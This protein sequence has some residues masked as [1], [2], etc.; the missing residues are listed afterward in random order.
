MTPSRLP[1][2][3]LM[4]DRDAHAMDPLF[5]W[6]GCQVEV[7]GA[8]EALVTVGPGHVVRLEPVS[9]DF[10]QVGLHHVVRM[11]RQVQG[12]WVRAL[13]AVVMVEPSGR[14]VLGPGEMEAASQRVDDR[15]SANQA[16][17]C[18]WMDDDGTERDAA[19]ET[20]D[21]SVGGCSAW[22]DP[23]PPTGIEV[24][25]AI[26]LE[27]KWWFVVARCL[28]RLND[29][30]ARFEFTATTAEAAGALTAFVTHRVQKGGRLPPT[31]GLPSGSVVRLRLWG[32]A[33]AAEVLEAEVNPFG[34]AVRGVPTGF[35]PGD[36]VVVGVLLDSGEVRM[37][38]ARV[39][40]RAGGKLRLAWA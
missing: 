3:S 35:E 38:S 18:W 30:R 24:A 15:V 37:G 33:R 39:V 40:S 36:G 21:V 9:G 12:A 34:L 8:G 32:W 16:A 22:L 7:A 4:D 11:A 1:M 26:E 31:D 28:A 27:R 5:S 19:G 29:G 2:E 13:A 14:L 6:V 25:L 23:V 10:S 17:A 20:V